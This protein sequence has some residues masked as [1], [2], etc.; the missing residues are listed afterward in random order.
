MEKD[1]E[2]SAWFKALDASDKQWTLLMRLYETHK[3]RGSLGTFYAMYA[4]LLTQIGWLK[5]SDEPRERT[6]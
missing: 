6:R 3:A 1:I 5:R 4:D 2:D